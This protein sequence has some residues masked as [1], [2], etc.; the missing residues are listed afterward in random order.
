M[1]QAYTLRLH[2][3]GPALWPEH[4][5]LEE[6]LELEATT[7]VGIFEATYQGNPTPPQGTVFLREFWD[8][9]N[10]YDPDDVKTKNIV[11]GRWISWDTGLK[12]NEDNAFTACTVGELLRN[13]TM[14]IREVWRERITFPE[15]PDEIARKAWKY[16]KDDKLRAVIIEDRVS[17]TSAFQTLQKT[18]EPW[19][20]KILVAFNPTDDKTTR[21]NQAAVWCRNNCVLM[22]IPG[23]SV[24]WLFDFEDELFDFPGSAFKDQVDSF[25]QLILWT[26]NL[27]S[28]GWKARQK[29]VS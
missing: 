19:L 12:D 7:P 17:G 15:L 6:V 14:V 3:N 21:A 27:L 24:P 4:K 28:A 26:E 23:V 11:V 13:Y 5:P 8:G 29:T 22:P 16:N 18:G 10:R 25:S 2:S 9:K 20:Q 1:P